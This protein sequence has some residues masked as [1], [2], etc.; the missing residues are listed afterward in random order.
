MK[1]L[2]KEADKDVKKSLTLWTNYS[3][4]GFTKNF[5]YIV[6]NEKKN[7]KRFYPLEH[8]LNSLAE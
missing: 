5:N 1:N 8:E 3:G 2:F 4:H 7:D 6:L